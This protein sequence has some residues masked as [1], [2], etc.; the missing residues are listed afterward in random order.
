[1]LNKEDMI[2]RGSNLTIIYSQKLL[3]QR[4]NLSN[5]NLKQS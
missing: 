1:M 5:S 4:A 3:H 2:N